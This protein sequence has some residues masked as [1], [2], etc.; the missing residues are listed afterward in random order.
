MKRTL[1]LFALLAAIIGCSSR[2]VPSRAPAS[3]G[4]IEQGDG[5]ALAAAMR[6]AA[7]A[8][9]SYRIGPSDLLSAT[10][11]Q[12]DALGRR[13]RVD[14][15]GAISLPLIGAVKVG[16][17]TI[18]EAQRAIEKKLS[19]FLVNPQVSLLV[20]AYGSKLVFVLGEVKKPG[21]YPIPTDSPMSVVQAISAAGGFTNIAAPSRTRVLRSAE[22]RGADYTVDVRAVTRGGERDK[23]LL[24]EPNDV[25]YVPQSFF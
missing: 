24:V 3:G 20:E 10:V 4:G 1:G 7:A 25:I 19:A 13:V 14:A 16:G 12:E 9:R 6:S 21:S 5:D 15:D 18:L 8:R 22:G 17:A 11:Y 23:D 2:T